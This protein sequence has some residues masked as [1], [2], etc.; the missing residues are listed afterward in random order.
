MCTLKPPFRSD[1]MQGLFKKV[2]KGQYSKI[3]SIYSNDLVT[4]IRYLLQ[5]TP[6]LRPD[7]FKILSI[8]NVV[9]HMTEKHMVEPDD[10]EKTILMNTIRIP[11]S[12]S[13]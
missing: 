9:R 12:M 10:T 6:H 2:I 4:I 13:K 5:V 1:D 8:P 11:R 3:P 7:C